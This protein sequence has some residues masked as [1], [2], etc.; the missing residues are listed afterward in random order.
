LRVLRSLYPEGLACCHHVLVHPP[1]G[2]AGGDN[3]ELTLHLASCSQALVTTPGATRFYRTRG[4][5]AAQTVSV[6][7][8][9]ASRLEWLPLETLVHDGARSTNE[10]HAALQGDARLIAW[11]V[12]ALGLPA[13]EQPF[14]RGQHRQRMAIDGL[15]L[16]HAVIDAAD[17]RLLRS[18]LG[19]AGHPVLGTA[20][21]ACGQSVGG[22][23]IDSMIETA[24]GVIGTHALSRTAGVTALADMRGVVLRV[25]APRVE[26]AWDLMRRVRAAWR[27]LWMGVEA[28][29]PRLWRL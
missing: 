1:A 24:R 7:M 9:D 28:V 12:L 15:W 27:P 29:E 5:E 19:W 3:L 10:F 11:D 2:I 18:P 14:V 26:P 8:E 21:A 17:H 4:D 25:L 23:A 22:A 20:V 6:Q 13:S 16:D